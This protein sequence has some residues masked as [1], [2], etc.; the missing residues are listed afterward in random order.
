M[1]LNTQLNIFIIEDNKMFALMLKNEL[2]KFL[3]S[4]NYHIHTFNRAEESESYLK[5]MPDLVLIDYHLDGNDQNAMDG[6]SAIEMIRKISPDTD[7]V[8]I[9]NDLETELF[10]KAKQLNIYDYLTKSTNVP[11][12]LNL[13]INQWLKWKK[14]A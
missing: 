6:L 12:K 5:L 7:F 8:M 4:Q 11:F 3:E 10:L 14:L 9:T 13:T 2:I 1:K